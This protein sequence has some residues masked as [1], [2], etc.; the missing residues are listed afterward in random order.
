V[1]EELF[2]DLRVRK[3]NEIGIGEGNASF[4]N[5]ISDIGDCVGFLL[6]VIPSRLS[7][8]KAALLFAS[9]ESDV[10]AVTEWPSLT[11]SFASSYVIRTGPPYAHAGAYLGTI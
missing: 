8:S 4:R 9:K 11:N 10:K 5:K 6:I 3:R 2:C 7:F 1:L